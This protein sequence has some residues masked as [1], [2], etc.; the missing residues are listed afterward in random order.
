MCFKS[1]LG[2]YTPKYAIHNDRTLKTKT[3]NL[4]PL[5]EQQQTRC[6]WNLYYNCHYSMYCAAIAR[7]TNV[8]HDRPNY[9]GALAVGNAMGRHSISVYNDMYIG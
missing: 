4:S 2:I 9:Y 6:K 1:L 7:H 3:N 5:G 8:G